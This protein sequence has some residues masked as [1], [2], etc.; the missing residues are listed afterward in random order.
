MAITRLSNAR[1]VQGY[2]SVTTLINGFDAT[3]IERLDDG[4]LILGWD[5]RAG[6]SDIFNVATLDPTG[7]TRS[8]ITVADSVPASRLTEQPKFA[9][10]TEGRPFMVWDRDNDSPGLTTG[11]SIAGYLGG[12]KF[13]LSTAPG[14]GEGSTSVTRLANGNF[15]AIWS[16]T[17][18]TS[19][20]RT[21]SDIMGR[22]IS[23][24]TGL[25]ITG[26]FRI[27]TATAGS[28]LGTDLETLGDG[29]AVAVWE[30]GNL[31]FS[32]FAPTGIKG[33]FIGPGGLPT[34]AEFSVDT[35]RGGSYEEKSLEVIALGNGGFAVAWEQTIG[36]TEEIHLQRFSALGVKLGA[37]TVIE[38]VGG[39]RNI[40]NFFTTEL[41]NGG[42]AIGWRL[43]GG[44]PE[45]HLIRQFD[46]NG[47][48]I[49]REAS[50]TA[51]AGTAGI[52]RFYDMELM[53]DGHVMMFGFRNATVATQVFDLGD[54]VLRGTA[55][56]DR[57]YGKDGVADVILGNAGIDAIFGL[58]G[59]DV[60]DGGLGNDSIN[61]GRGNDILKGGDGLDTLT[62]A[63]GNDTFVFDLAPAAL[64]NSDTIA[65]FT[66][67]VDTIQLSAAVFTQ[68][69]TG[70]LLAGQFASA[71]DGL[72]HAP[73]E[74]I[75]YNT[76]TG[77]LSYDDDGDG[78][79]AAVQFAVLS[80]LPGIASADFL[81]V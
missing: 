6:A 71:A 64:T 75:I 17:L 10:T 3:R 54:E 80:G 34:G 21:S 55:G 46:V 69:T 74:R 70:A 23:A 29:R 41:A 35:I 27:N 26:E 25:P 12:P 72:A 15:L 68:L 52:Q 50:L 22:I 76:T 61:G 14:G 20:L 73:G 13:N 63:A 47:V 24:N 32:G 58:S 4:R 38:S 2:A 8:A 78:A 19:G 59:D 43:T 44:G 62:G 49:G 16:D 79:N 48:E 1:T 11:D 67:T 45:T 37:E 9:S 7:I 60:I 53:S 51:L 56:N 81:V 18:A 28:Q 40:L 30:T 31:T 77:A 33:R 39:A 42:Y 5:T 57:L 66:T 36:S 65:D